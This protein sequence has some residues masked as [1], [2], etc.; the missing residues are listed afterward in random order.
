MVRFPMDADNLGVVDARGHCHVALSGPALLLESMCPTICQRL[1]LLAHTPLTIKLQHLVAL[2]GDHMRPDASFLA[3]K[4]ACDVP[5]P[6]VLGRVLDVVLP[7]INES[8]RHPIVPCACVSVVV[9][10]GVHEILHDDE[11]LGVGQ[12]ADCGRDACRRLR[13]GFVWPARYGRVIEA[14]DVHFEHECG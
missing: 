2:V 6:R 12:R 5:E 10:V 8:H 11:A 7:A 4:V 3:R 14:C 1:H 13:H 9:L